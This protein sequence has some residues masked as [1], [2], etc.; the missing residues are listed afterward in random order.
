ML[1]DI[2][3][4]NPESILAVEGSVGAILLDR[5][6]ASGFR[7]VIRNHLIEV[8]SPNKEKKSYATQL[9]TCFR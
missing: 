6:M 2:Q 1:A 5:L 9:E 8:I 3:K 4:T 7:V